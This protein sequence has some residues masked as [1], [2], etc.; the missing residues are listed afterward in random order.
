MSKN[1]LVNMDKKANSIAYD[2]GA[3][4][5]LVRN[6][7]RTPN[8]Y[9]LPNNC[10]IV[11]EG[12][13]MYGKTQYIINLLRRRYNC[14]TKKW[15]N[16]PLDGEAVHIVCPTFD[17][18]LY[19][20]IR[21]IKDEEEEA[22]PELIF[23]E[24]MKDLPSLDS[25]KKGKIRQT[26]IFDD[27]MNMDNSIQNQIAEFF[28]RGRHKNLDIAYIAQLYYEI[29]KKVRK[30]ANVLISFNNN[31]RTIENMHRDFGSGANIYKFK[32][33]FFNKEKQTVETSEGPKE[34]NIPKVIIN[35]RELRDGISPE[36]TV[37]L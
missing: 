28:C 26:V 2:P 32:N 30:N 4:M 1:E 29:P 6:K 25:F 37:N 13:S 34:Y 36:N 5:D 10:L 8:L 11:V 12:P 16:G 23:Y 9:K 20:N 18:D 33:W 14:F 31:E 35:N 15:E 22:F 21:E 17:Q 3:S 7:P 19:K 24:H 27:V